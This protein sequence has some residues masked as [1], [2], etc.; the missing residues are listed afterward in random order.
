MATSALNDLSQERNPTPS[1][2]TTNMD[3][4]DSTQGS[5]QYNYLGDV[6][7]TGD[8]KSEDYTGIDPRTSAEQVGAT[9]R[10]AYESA[11]D[12]V[13]TPELGVESYDPNKTREL[14]QG[15]SQFKDSASYIDRAT[16]TVA[17][18]LESLLNKENPLMK[19]Q[20][21]QA[22]VRSARM[23]K[24][25]SS[26]GI[27]AAQGALISSALPIAQQDAQTYAQAAGRQQAAEYGATTSEKEAVLSG[28]VQKYT[29]EID[30]ANK[31]IDQRF[32]A[33]MASADAETQAAMSE[34][35]QQYK[36]DYAVLD[37][38]IRETLMNQEIDAKSKQMAYEQSANILQNY[39]VTVENM[40]TNPSFLEMGKESIVNAI[41][42]IQ[43]L[44][45]NQVN[46]IGN[47]VG[48]DFTDLID[49]YF[50]DVLTVEDIEE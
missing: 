13:G 22:E 20:E 31:N 32:N 40:L 50:D 41:N 18:Q 49:F 44:A 11:L 37:G 14:L 19:Q 43:N 39:Q 2:E 1:Y 10:S 26:M 35:Q 30:R 9:A 47:A 16:G 12:R 3:R 8:I 5:T 42:Q 7:S 25:G 27:G 36:A 24:L 38:K 4:F 48:V 34:L 28:E 21:S 6:P 46:F 45:T 17:G 29:A 15:T 23:G 33:I